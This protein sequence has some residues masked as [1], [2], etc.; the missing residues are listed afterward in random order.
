MSTAQTLTLDQV[1][2]TD[3][4]PLPEPDSAG[5]QA[6]IS[7]ARHE[8]LTLG[9]TVLP[10]FI[11]PALRTA[12]EREC[13]AIAPQA[14][15]DIET[16]NV[17]NIAVDSA[18]PADHPGR[19]TFQRGNAFVPR[20]RVPADSLIS[21]LYSEPVFQDFL[22]RCFG[23]PRLHEL[24]DPLSGLVLNVVA[25]GM[26]HPWHFDTNEFTVSMLTR[27]AQDGGVFE[28]CP[29]I[30]SA[31][32]EHFD[33][34]R[35]VL[36]G[37]GERLIRRLPLH[38]GDLQLFKGRYSLHRVSPVR[39]ETARHS[40]IFAYSERPGVIGSV[41]RTRQLF[42]RVLPAHTAAE[43]RAVRGDRLLD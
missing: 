11:R 22:A 42:G 31:H 16:V 40:A 43:G 7:R 35:D 1:V 36:D 25:P 3:R 8:L 14:H 32:D 26:E 39:G 27:Q 12:L 34:V 38:P 29:N 19:R 30:R 15:Y 6:V 5:G 13:A 20:D 17:Y 21:R 41:A 9:C 37:R 24:A 18:L 23:L 28:Y 10:D 4:Y 33:D 2:D